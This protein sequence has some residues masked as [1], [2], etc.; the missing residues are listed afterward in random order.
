MTG[1]EL[2]KIGPL[3]FRMGL[4]GLCRLSDACGTRP[5]ASRAQPFSYFRLHFTEFFSAC[6]QAFRALGVKFGERGYAAWSVSGSGASVL[7]FMKGFHSV[8]YCVRSRKA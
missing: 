6:Y 1:E 2:L 7:R 4:Q 3:L 5:K 8:N